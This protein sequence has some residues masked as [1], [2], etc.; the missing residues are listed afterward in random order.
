MVATERH[1]R[2]MAHII[3]ADI[4]SYLVSTTAC[5]DLEACCVAHDTRFILPLLGEYV[6]SGYRTP[7]D[8]VIYSLK[9]NIRYYLM[10]LGLIILGLVYV[11]IQNGF[12]GG[13]LR[14]LAMALAYMV[15]LIQAIYLMGHGL[16]A[17]PRQLLRNASASGKLRRLQSSAPKVHEKMEDAITELA[18]LDQQ[19]NELQARKNGVSR[20]HEEWIEDLVDLNPPAYNRLSSAPPPPAVPT[21]RLP[22]VITDRYLADI[23]RRLTRARHRRIRFISEWEHLVQSAADTQAIIDSFASRRLDF[24][25]ATGH[26]LFSR[27][28]LTPSV[29]YRLHAQVLPAARI[30]FGALLA[31]ASAAVVWSEIFKHFAPRIS[32]VSLTVLPHPSDPRMSLF[33]QMLA[34]LW[35]LYMSFA[36]LSPLPSIKVW[37]NRALV[38]RNTYAESACWYATQ[39]AK[40]S[41]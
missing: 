10:V 16:V 3:L 7:R 31:L 36:A 15:G 34:F 38:R 21:P 39:I 35:L 32:I 1:A 24:G 19:V 22:A 18:E 37:G 26:S 28:L 5:S 25:H 9:N 13:S 12:D 2:G 40:L 33:R 4:L 20:D 27:P 23:S 17:I 41:K 8:R 6:D 14:S 30:C 11:I 29:R